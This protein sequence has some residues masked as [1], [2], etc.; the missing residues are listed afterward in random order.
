MTCVYNERYIFVR[1]P[2]LGWGVRDRHHLRTA[3]WGTG[4]YED[5]AREALED[6]RNGTYEAD[7]FV[8]TEDAEVPA[9]GMWLNALS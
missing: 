8:W 9:A 4:E 3:F 7:N 1:H 6:L 2:S 5:D